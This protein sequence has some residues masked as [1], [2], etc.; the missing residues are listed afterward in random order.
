MSPYLIVLNSFD[1]VAVEDNGITTI[2]EHLESE[3]PL[4]AGDDY[5][6]LE[7]LC[8]QI[9]EHERDVHVRAVDVLG[10][11]EPDGTFHYI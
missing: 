1:Y 11:T 5:Y 9:I 10:V 2:G 8:A 7:R 4:H 3:T 6:E